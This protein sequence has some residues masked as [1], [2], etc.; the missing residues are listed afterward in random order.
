MLAATMNPNTG[1]GEHAA[2]YVELQVIEWLKEALG[3]PS[4]ASGLL[5]SGGSMANLIGLAVARNAKAGF[6]V[7]SEGIHSLKQRITFYTSDQT[8]SSVRKAIELLGIGS[9]NLIEVATDSSYRI[10]LQ[11][12]R[13]VIK[14]DREAGCL[15]VCVIGNAGTTNTGAVDSLAELADIAL[16]ENLWFHVDGAFGDLAFLSEKRRAL[17][18]GMVRAD[19]LA[20][21]LH[22]WLYVPYDAGCILIRD[23]EAHHRSFSTAGSY[24]GH[25]ASGLQGGDV[26]FSEYGLELSRRFRALKVWMSIKEH[27]IH[28]YGE[29]I[30]QNCSQAAYLAE[31]LQEYASELELVAP[32]AL[33]VVCFRYRVPGFTAEDLNLL[34]RELL[35][36]LYADGTVAPSH[37][38]MGMTYSLRVAITNHRSRRE[39]FDILITKVLQFGRELVKEYH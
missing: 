31:R 12:L 1:V 28:K 27:G 23:R 22:K 16:E 18:D 25:S 24:L 7:M 33:N 13:R 34:N 36:R 4:I 19:S 15:P 17:L 11:E 38:I 2:G 20:F 3:M 8:H 35:L 39:D 26:W 30:E 29:V 10:D 6:E 9:D 32:V 21:D 5:V 37:A 14:R